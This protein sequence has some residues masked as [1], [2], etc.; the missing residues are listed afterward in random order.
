MEPPRS[1]WQEASTNRTA[2]HPATKPDLVT[3]YCSSKSLQDLPEWSPPAHKKVL[4]GA[5]DPFVCRSRRAWGRKRSPMPGGGTGTPICR[6]PPPGHRTTCSSRPVGGFTLVVPG[7]HHR[8][9]GEAP[10]L[11]RRRDRHPTPQNG[12][13]L[14]G[15]RV[16]GSGDA[17]YLFLLL[18][19]HF[20]LP[21]TR[22]CT[23]AAPFPDFLSTMRQMRAGGGVR[24]S[25]APL[26]AAVGNGN[27][28]GE[29]SPD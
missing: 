14:L 9:G 10:A 5:A 19:S 4:S 23:L 7:K 17:W 26:R 1:C 22:F 18:F 6:G 15:G 8:A 12:P 2:P 27:G 16:S 29:N 25:L 21:L 20:T 28:I 11:P 13:P 24:T 3:L